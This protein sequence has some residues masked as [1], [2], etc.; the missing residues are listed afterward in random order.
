[1]APGLEDV[2]EAGVELGRHGDLMEVVVRRVSEA[3]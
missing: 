1:L 2:I 3:R